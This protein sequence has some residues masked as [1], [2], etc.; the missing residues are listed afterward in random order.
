MGWVSP[1]WIDRVRWTLAIGNLAL[2]G[3]GFNDGGVGLWCAPKPKWSYG[4]GWQH[5]RPWHC[6]DWSRW[7]KPRSETIQVQRTSSP[8]LE[9]AVTV[10][11]ITS[12]GRGCLEEGCLGLPGAF[13]DIFGPAIFPRKRKKK[14][15]R[16]WAPR[17][18]LELP[19][20]L[21]PDLREDPK[22]DPAQKVGTRSRT[23]LTRGSRQA[24][25]SWCPKSWNLKHF[26]IRGSFPPTFPRFFPEFSS[27]APEQTPETATAFSSFL[28]AAFLSCGALQ[29]GERL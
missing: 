20:V 18:G 15:A 28:I 1:S 11:G 8:K 13:P 16:T 22:K 19:D 14:T 27:E 24:C 9:K 17:L 6:Q 23:V 2:G 5:W 29:D 4:K 10:N 21:L 25:L 3:G 7:C 26:A 12:E